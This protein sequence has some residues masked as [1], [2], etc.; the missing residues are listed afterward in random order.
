MPETTRLLHV[1]AGA[2]AAG[3]MFLAA[4]IDLGVPVAHLNRT[5]ADLPLSGWR[6]RSSRIVRCGLSARRVDVRVTESGHG[7]GWKAIEKIVRGGKLSEGVRRRSLAI[8]RRLI[9][10]EAEVHGLPAERVHLHEAGGVDAII[11]IVGA[12]IALERLAIDRVV[13]SPMTTGFGTVEC[14]HG[15]YPVP[16]PATLA[17]VRGFPVVA[18]DIEVERLTPTGAAILTTIADDWGAFPM[19]RPLATGYGAGS[20]DLGS[21]P[22]ML[23]VILGERESAATPDDSADRAAVVVVECTIDDS[24]PQ[25]LAYTGEQLMAAGALEVA[26]GSVTMKKGRSGHRLTVLVRG[27]RLQQICDVIVRE[28]STLGLRYHEERRVELQRTSHAV[29]TAYGKITVKVGS[30]AGRELQAWPEYEECAAQARRHGVAL[31]DVQQAALESYRSS[32][33]SDSK[34]PKRAKRKR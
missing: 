21:S 8:F 14:S 16:A 13:V 9:E 2:G 1:D 3:D 22:N 6:L 30:L 23:R 17:L 27:E 28:T 33:K 12:C 34:K 4:L 15:R 7:R 24:T 5:L 26:T 32:S 29:R 11:D 18:G 10:A 31:A 19:M 25:L 20:R